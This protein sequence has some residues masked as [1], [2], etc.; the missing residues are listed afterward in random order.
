MAGL[1]IFTNIL[2]FILASFI[3]YFGYKAHKEG[4]GKIATYLTMAFILFAFSYL[5]YIIIDIFGVTSIVAPFSSA[6][7]WISL[8]IITRIVAYALIAFALLTTIKKMRKEKSAQ[9]TKNKS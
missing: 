3:V 6:V 9:E 1:G 2:N 4:A 5:Q 7:K 8:I